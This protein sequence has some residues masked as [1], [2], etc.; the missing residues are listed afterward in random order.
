M[1]FN[2][3]K[4]NALLT[5]QDEY[6]ITSIM[7]EENISLTSELIRDAIVHKYG[8]I[9]TLHARQITLLYRTDI[10]TWDLRRTACAVA[11]S[12]CTDHKHPEI[13]NL[14][15]FVAWA[16]KH[17]EGIPFMREHDPFRTGDYDPTRPM[18][19]LESLYQHLERYEKEAEIIDELHALHPD[20][21]KDVLPGNGGESC[22]VTNH[23]E[24]N[25]AK[26]G[27]H[28]KQAKSIEALI[29]SPDFTP[30]K[31]LSIL[32]KYWP[33][34]VTPSVFRSIGTPIAYCLYCAE[35]FPDTPEA[36]NEFRHAVYA[37]HVPEK[38]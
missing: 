12:Y 26:G 35:E 10:P 13:D 37:I 34:Y 23:N 15:N 32:R 8:S 24:Y 31:G 33:Y 22:I 17:L 38:L 11:E 2:A 28:H 36:R 9:S 3:T 20:Y 18:T 14:V 19:W 6:I 5:S 21:Y 7:R 25:A 4:K 30:S 27:W 1:I 29:K 16:E